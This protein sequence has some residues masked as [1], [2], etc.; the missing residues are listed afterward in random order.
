MGNRELTHATQVS[1]LDGRAGE[2]DV[3]ARPR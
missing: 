3:V 1:S 2:L